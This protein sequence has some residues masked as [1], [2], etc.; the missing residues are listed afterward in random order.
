MWLP[1]ELL[2]EQGVVIGQDICRREEIQRIIPVLFIELLKP[3]NVLDHQVLA[4]QLYVI[5]EV[6]DEL[7]WLQ[8]DAIIR[9]EY[10]M[11]RLHCRPVYVPSLP[12]PMVLLP[13]STCEIANNAVILEVTTPTNYHAL[14]LQDVV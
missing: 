12:V 5:G 13:L 6:V 11:Y 9:L 1:F 8:T 4:G 3:F 14:V 7:V 10:L 2:C